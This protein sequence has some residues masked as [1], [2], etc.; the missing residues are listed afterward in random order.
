MSRSAP[1]DGELRAAPQPG[2]KF[3]PFMRDYQRLRDLAISPAFWIPIC[4]AGSLIVIALGFVVHTHSVL[5][6]DVNF[7]TAVQQVHIVAFQ[8]L[9]ILISTFGYPP[10]AE[11][12]EAVAIVA[13]LLLR[14]PLEALFLALTLLV[15]GLAA[16]VKIIVARPRPSP[17][18]VLVLLRLG[19]YSYPSGH[20][21]HYTIFYGFLIVVLVVC[22]RS[23]WWRTTLIAICAAL[24]A[25]VGLSRIYLGEHWLSDVVA[26]YLLAG[27][28][29]VALVAAY[30]RFR[31]EDSLTSPQPAQGDS[32]P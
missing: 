16:L 26:G 7:T 31:G 1:M 5:P 29:L 17:K 27:V 15:D 20:V 4:A 25:L 19:S 2:R 13:L 28:C 11:I 14:R 18:D 32:A 24:I 6:V 30:R 23:S 12:I 10:W 21:V 9:M 8:R 3:V 22:W